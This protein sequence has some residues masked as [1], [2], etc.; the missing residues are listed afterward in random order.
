MTT[1]PLIGDDVLVPLPDPY[2]PHQDIAAAMSWLL[3]R[4]A[5]VMQD[6]SGDVRRGR[7]DRDRRRPGASVAHTGGTNGANASHTA[8]GNHSSHHLVLTQAQLSV[9]LSRPVRD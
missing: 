8:N 4:T 7:H 6:L 9:W 1:L 3:S 5:A 2:R